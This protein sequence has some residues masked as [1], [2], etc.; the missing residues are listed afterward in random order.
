MYSYDRTAGEGDA[1]KATKDAVAWI[2]RLENLAKKAKSALKTKGDGGV[3]ELSEFV[4]Q[5]KGYRDEGWYDT[6]FG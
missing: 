3:R 4:G 6:F 2:E 1:D 5:L